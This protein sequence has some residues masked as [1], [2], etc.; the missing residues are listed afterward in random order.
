MP[1]QGSGLRKAAVELVRGLYDLCRQQENGM[2]KECRTPR[3][4]VSNLSNC[5]IVFIG[6]YPLEEY[7]G[8]FEKNNV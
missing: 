1:S 5:R 4:G 8:T 7:L 6:D 2:K 3:N